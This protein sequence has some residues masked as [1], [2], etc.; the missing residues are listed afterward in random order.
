LID[1]KIAS[2]DIKSGVLVCPGPNIAYF[3][4]KVSLKKM[5]Q[6]I[7]GKTANLTP[8]NRP[9]MFVKELEMY[10]NYFNEKL[11]EFKITPDDRKQKKYL[12]KYYKNINEGITYYQ[13]LFKDATF[14]ANFSG[15]KNNLQPF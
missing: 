13:E 3:D 1:K 2:K 8:L 9:N 12:T 10:V 5:V 6:H 7:Y 15:L 14:A 4:K 11:E